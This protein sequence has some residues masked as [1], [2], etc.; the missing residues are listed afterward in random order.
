M[1]CDRPDLFFSRLAT[2]D[3]IGSRD[4]LYPIAAL[5]NLGAANGLGGRLCNLISVPIVLIFAR[6]VVCAPGPYQ[7]D[8]RVFVFAIER[9][10]T[11]RDDMKFSIGR[12]TAIFAVSVAAALLMLAPTLPAQAQ[13][14]PAQASPAHSVVAPSANG[15]T[16]GAP[17]GAETAKPAAAATGKPTTHKATHPK[18]KKPSF[19]NKMRDKATQQVQKLF[20]SKPE[21]PQ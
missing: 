4:D 2:V 11:G 3:S 14:N 5:T 12:V 9:T 19:I 21:S 17:S 13:A 16:Q 18:K 1:L 20:G 6:V 7:P 15:E 10:K 8:F